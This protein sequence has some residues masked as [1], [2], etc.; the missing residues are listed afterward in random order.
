MLRRS[1]LWCPIGLFK[2]KIVSLERGHTRDILHIVIAL[3]T[4]EDKAIRLIRHI[5][6]P[7]FDRSNYLDIRGLT[8][9]KPQQLRSPTSQRS[10]TSGE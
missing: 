5:L 4:V 8:Q 6:A 10:R 1:L 2:A 3:A 9:P 7:F